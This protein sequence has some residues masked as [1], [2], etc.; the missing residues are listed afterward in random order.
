MISTGCICMQAIDIRHIALDVFFSYFLIQSNLLKS[1][2]PF[3]T[4]THEQTHFK[5]HLLIYFFSTVNCVF[6]SYSPVHRFN[7]LFFFLVFITCHFQRVLAHTRHIRLVDAMII[8][9]YSLF[10][11][12]IFFRLKSTYIYS[13]H[14]SSSSVIH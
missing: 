1:R 2:L 13:V 3:V 5:R 12:D 8:S 14:F 11:Y 7:S 9:S 10:F 4:S 6:S